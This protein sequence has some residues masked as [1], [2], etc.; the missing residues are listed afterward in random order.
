VEKILLDVMPIT[1]L[2]L[3]PRPATAGATV[4]A[5][6]LLLSFGIAGES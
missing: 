4:L 6:Q 3:D 1:V 5:G 2:G